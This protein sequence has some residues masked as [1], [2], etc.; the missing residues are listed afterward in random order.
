MRKTDFPFSSSLGMTLLFIGI[1]MI[2][3][4]LLLVA[5]K[6]KDYTV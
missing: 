4:I 1:P 6:V 2:L 3:G 5:P